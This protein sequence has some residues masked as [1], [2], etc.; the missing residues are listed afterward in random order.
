M[1]PEGTFT[2]FFKDEKSKRESHNSRNQGFSYYFCMMIEGSG[3]GTGSL[4]LSMQHWSEVWIRI[5]LPFSHK[6]VEQTEI[7]L[8]K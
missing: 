5:R 4:P 3:S 2:S 1:D 8:G 7:M 6:G